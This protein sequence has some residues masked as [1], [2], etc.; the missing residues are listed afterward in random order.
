MSCFTPTLTRAGLALLIVAASG[1]PEPA[2]SA[3]YTAYPGEY[4][5]VIKR[6]E[7]PNV[8]AVDAIVWTGFSRALRI[9]LPGIEVPTASDDAPA[10]Q[11]ELAERAQSLSESFLL[12]AKAVKVRDIEMENTGKDDAYA[13]LYTERGSLSDALLKAGLARPNGTEADTPWC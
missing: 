11:R 6:I 1:M 7:R 3:L 9:T 13:P 12:G 10:C 2:N 5:V 4:P 8:I